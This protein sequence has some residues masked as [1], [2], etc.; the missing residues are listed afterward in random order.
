[1]D[2][3]EE[4]LAGIIKN[5]LSD[6]RNNI[7]KLDQKINGLKRQKQSLLEKLRKKEKAYRLITGRTV[8]PRKQ[9]PKEKTDVK[10]VGTEQ[11]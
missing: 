1:M 3:R 6:E 9:P 2:E 5:V 8:G 11:L 4:E 7:G 10:P